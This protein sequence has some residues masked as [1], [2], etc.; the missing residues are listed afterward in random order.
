MA[1]LASYAERSR[2]LLI[3]QSRR[4]VVTKSKMCE[5]SGMADNYWRVL[6]V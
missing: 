6:R 1:V 4:V 3:L 5:E 2:G